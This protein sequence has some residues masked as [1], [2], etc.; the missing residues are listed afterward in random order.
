MRILLPW[1]LAGMARR[2]NPGIADVFAGLRQRDNE[3]ELLTVRESPR[4]AIA[5]GNWI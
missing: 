1:I 4:L 2:P 5:L 3:V